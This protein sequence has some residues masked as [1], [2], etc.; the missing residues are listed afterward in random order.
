M[1][2]NKSR[3]LQLKEGIT[4]KK[5]LVALLVVASLSN[6]NPE[7]CESITLEN[8]QTCVNAR[9]EKGEALDAII[10][11]MCNAVTENEAAI[12]ADE[13]VKIKNYLEEQVRCT[14][15]CVECTDAQ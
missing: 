3:C 1:R 8:V 11:D 5:L 12:N 10:A 13:L 15:V 7:M 9:L 14:T 6:A 2:Y 4:M